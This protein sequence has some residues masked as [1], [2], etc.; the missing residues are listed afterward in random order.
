MLRLHAPAKLNLYLRILGRRPDGYHELET[1]FERIDLADELTFKP[2]AR[3]I[4]MTC[5]DPTLA[6]GASN[7][8]TKAAHLLQQTCNVS[9]GAAIHLA[10]RIPIAA[11]L[12]GGSSDAAATLIGL[13]RLWALRLSAQRLRQLAGPLG[14]DVPFFL[15]RGP[16]AVGRGRGDACEPVAGGCPTLWQVVVVPTA[17]L[18]TQDVYEGFDAAK[19][20]KKSSL[21]VSRRSI[22]MLLHALRNGS[23]SELAS[24]LRNDLQPE[25][26]RRCPVIQDIQGFLQSCPC[27]G[28]MVSGSGPSVF[29]LC[30]DRAHAETASRRLREKGGSSWRIAV[31]KTAT[32]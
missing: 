31:V 9:Q 23:L 27:L 17:R 20:L 11:G 8:V 5:D 21:T 24:G 19:P 12:G 10:K 7:L 4:T 15:E 26:I 28:T 14:A 25:A 3:G 6:C 13:N 30:Q 32:R 1:L 29:G 16:F 22:S 18:S 2:Q